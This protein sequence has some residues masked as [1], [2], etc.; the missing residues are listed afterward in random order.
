[1]DLC[2]PVKNA[3]EMISED[4]VH[5]TE[6]GNKMLAGVIIRSIKNIVPDIDD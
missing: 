5:L 6:E 1:M 4:G 3:P 2:T